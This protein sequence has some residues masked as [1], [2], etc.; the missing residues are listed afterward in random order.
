MLSENQ[1]MKLE[2]LLESLEETVSQIDQG[3]LRVSEA[4]ENVQK[5][6]NDLNEILEKDSLEWRN[7]R[8]R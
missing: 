7:I 8:Q 2:S 3:T 4:Q 6:D 5:V 1:I